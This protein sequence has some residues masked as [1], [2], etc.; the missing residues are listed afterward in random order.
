MFERFKIQHSYRL[1]ILINMQLLNQRR[2]RM[3]TT[4]HPNMCPHKHHASITTCKWV[5]KCTSTTST[6]QPTNCWLMPWLLIPDGLVWVFQKL[7]IYWDFQAQPSLGL[8][9][10]GPKKRKYPVSGS[11]VGENVL[12]MAENGQTGSSW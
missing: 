7:L 9:E 5:H 1:R 8:T 6:H 10:N 11:S 2:T 4:T 3:P 12:L